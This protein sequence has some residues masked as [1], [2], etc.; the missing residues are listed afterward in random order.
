MYALQIETLTV[1]TC[2]QLRSCG[3]HVCKSCFKPTL[4]SATRAAFKKTRKHV[5]KWM[6]PRDVHHPKHALKPMGGCETAY[7]PF[8][9]L[10]D[11]T[12]PYIAKTR[13]LP[14]FPM[15]YAVDP[16]KDDPILDE[17]TVLEGPIFHVFTSMIFGEMVNHPFDARGIAWLHI[18]Q[19]L[20][21]LF[22][23]SRSSVPLSAFPLQASQWK[24]CPSLSRI[25]QMPPA[26]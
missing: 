18:P 4:A 25:V 15:M 24:D 9:V 19:A 10:D 7:L 16:N 22:P 21:P 11:A 6:A 12:M 23:S 3:I 20:L 5:F 17:T 2:Y 26:I 14:L 13:G 8:T 1:C